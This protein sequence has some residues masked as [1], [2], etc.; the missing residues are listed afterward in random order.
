MY[1]INSLLLSNQ[2]GDIISGT[3]RNYGFPKGSIIMW[4]SNQIPAGWQECN[5]EFGTPDLRGRFPLGAGSSVDGTRSVFLPNTTGGS[6]THS[7]TTNEMPSHSH[8]GTTD[9]AGWG[10][11]DKCADN[12]AGKFPQSGGSHAHAFTTDPTGSTLGSSV[13]TPGVA[14]NNMPPYYV[15]K[16]IIKL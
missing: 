5:G 10:A 2:R 1:P 9:P 4:N 11:V 12:G 13:G 8:T 3:S 15:L 6:E 14:H 16:F 7:L